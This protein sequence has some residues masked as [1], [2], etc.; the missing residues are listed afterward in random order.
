MIDVS[1]TPS[2]IEALKE[3]RAR[4]EA[5][6]LALRGAR[7]E[8]LELMGEVNITMVRSC[9]DK[10]VLYG[11]VN[12]RDISDALQEAGYDVGVRSVRLANAIRRI[13][14][15]P[16]PIQFDKD[17]RTEVTI[18]IEP[19]QPL[20]EREEVEIDDEG[21]MIMPEDRDREHKKRER[22][23]ERRKKRREDREQKE[24]K[25]APGSPE[26]AESPA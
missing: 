8:L 3:R 23:E 5:E 11:S 21:N 14:E 13:G 4:A 1:G 2:K 20:E 24:E 12:Q 16:V 18:T 7:K 22:R 15:Y 10:G 6:M 26:P 19:D 25:A 17:L 9:N